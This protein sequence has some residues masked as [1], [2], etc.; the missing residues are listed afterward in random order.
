MAYH[1]ATTESRAPNNLSGHGLF[2][3]LAASAITL[4]DTALVSPAMPEIA[5][6]FADKAQ[7]EPFARAMLD[8]LS[9][10]PGEADAAFLVKFV[11][12][13]NIALFI[14]VGAPI[15]G[16]IC[17]R[18]GRKRVLVLSLAGFVVSGTSTY[19]ADSFLYLFVARAILGVMIAGLKTSTVAIVG[20][21]YKG[22]E[23]NKVIGWQGAA[24]KMTGVAFLLGGGFLANFH[25]NIPFLGYLLVLL[26][27]PSAI[28]ALKESLP[29]RARPI[30]SSVSELVKATPDVPFWPCA[31]VFVSA[32]LGSGFFFIT[33]VQLPFYLGQGF[34]TVPFQTGAAVAV[35]NT[36]GG[37]TA[38]LYG[39]LKLRFNYPGIYALNFLALATGY[40][41]LVLAPSYPFVLLGMLIAGVGFGLYIPNQSSWILSIV[42]EARRG[43]GVGLVTTGMFVGQFCAP[44]LVQPFIVA[45]D[46][47]A[48]WSSVSMILLVLAVIYA[49]MSLI[50]ARRGGARDLETSAAGAGSGTS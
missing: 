48:V 27:L 41:V 3:I 5:A 1:L 22:A 12:L 14:L 38:L 43:L 42:S 26:I 50:Y 35:G 4:M 29:A 7:T 20:D 45:A 40:Y 16:W 21:F 39:R 10:L 24:F 34:D 13:S 47:R 9:I 18:W 49:A 11:L 44:L 6:R 17:D 37:I 25:W 46:P 33:L 32:V 30:T 2:V 36:V 19:F 15:M 23:R 8:I 28:F 31:L